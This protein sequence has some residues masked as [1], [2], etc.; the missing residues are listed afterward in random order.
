MADDFETHQPGLTSPATAA[1]TIAP[2]NTVA[3]SHVTRAIYVGSA[4]DLRVTLV[5]GG[6]VTLTGVQ[7][8]VIY[9]LR[10][11]HV[12]ATGTTATGLVGLR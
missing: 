5:G 7:G 9:P 6:T 4:G 8:G 12:L 11:T 3:L 1:E 2:S 10:A